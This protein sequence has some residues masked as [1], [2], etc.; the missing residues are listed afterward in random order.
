MAWGYS[1]D[2]GEPVAADGRT[3]K[4]RGPDEGVPCEGRVSVFPCNRQWLGQSGHPS[5]GAHQPGPLQKRSL[6]PLAT[7]WAPYSPPL[8]SSSPHRGPSSFSVI[9]ILLTEV[10]GLRRAPGMF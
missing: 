10:R 8:P 2:S 1:S 9:E 3:A 6:I 7:E 5:L 4:G